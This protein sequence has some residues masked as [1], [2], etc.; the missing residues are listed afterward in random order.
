MPI[1][2]DLDD[3]VVAIYDEGKAFHHTRW[4]ATL[5]RSSITVIRAS[6]SRV[7]VEQPALVEARG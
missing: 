5:H 2:M 4:Q 6:R 7:E 3:E 1:A